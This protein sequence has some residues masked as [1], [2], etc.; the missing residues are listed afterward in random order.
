M[1]Y[2]SSIFKKRERVYKTYFSR[3]GNLKLS[4]WNGR[5]EIISV[6]LS[7]WNG[8]KNIAKAFIFP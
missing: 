2:A 7:L 3:K 8:R 5:Y 6:E 1:K 4:L